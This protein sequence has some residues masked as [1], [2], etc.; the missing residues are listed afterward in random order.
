V[1]NLEKNIAL[2]ENQVKYY[3]STQGLV[4]IFVDHVLEE[5]LVNVQI[6]KYFY[7]KAFQLQELS[8]Q[9]SILYK[10]N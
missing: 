2:L 4:S 10:E 3:K 1:Y 9:L 7:T 8:L 6:K 5:L